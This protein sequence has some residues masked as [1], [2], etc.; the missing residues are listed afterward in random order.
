VVFRCNQMEVEVR[1]GK[2]PFP[3]LMSH[4]AYDYHPRNQRRC[5]LC[6]VSVAESEYV[7]MTF[8]LYLLT[9]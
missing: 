1:V 2:F 8:Q 7:F 5:Y 9:L 6:L 3:R 4:A